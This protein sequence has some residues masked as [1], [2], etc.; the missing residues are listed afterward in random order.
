MRKPLCFQLGPMSVRIA[1]TNSDHAELSSAT[2]QPKFL[3]AYTA[4]LK[5][6]LLT[7][8]RTSDGSKWTMKIS[9]PT[10]HLTIDAPGGNCL[11]TLSVVFRSTKA[12]GFNSIPAWLEA[13]GLLIKSLSNLHKFKCTKQHT[14]AVHSA[15]N[16]AVPEA[17]TAEP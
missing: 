11:P 14:Q 1:S 2:C 10:G 6:Y 5:P 15:N 16:S 3:H 8:W 12:G 4:V 9:A 13:H 17:S 7:C